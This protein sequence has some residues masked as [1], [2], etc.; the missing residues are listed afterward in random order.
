M[1]RKGMHKAELENAFRAIGLALN[2]T[3]NTVAT[4]VVGIEP[5]ETSWRVN[6]EKEIALLAAIYD[7]IFSGDIFHVINNGAKR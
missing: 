7:V 3:H 5:N 4:D 6:N 1:E 2:A